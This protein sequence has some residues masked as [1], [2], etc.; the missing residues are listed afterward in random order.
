MLLRGLA[1]PLRAIVTNDE[2]VL[3]I[4][5]QL[6]NE[7]GTPCALPSAIS[8]YRDKS[9]MQAVF[10]QAGLPVPRSVSKEEDRSPEQKV[11]VK[12]RDEA[13]LRGISVTTREALS[14]Y[15][16]KGKVIEEFLEGPQFHCELLVR[17]GSVTPLFAGHYVR[18]LLELAAG[19]IS[20]S[21][22]TRGAHGARVEELAVAACEALGVDGHFVAHAEFLSRGADPKE[23]VLGE[24]CARAPGGEVPFQSRVIAG[25]DLETANLCLQAGIEPRTSRH[26]GSES[27]GWLWSSRPIDVDPAFVDP[28][29]PGVRA[30]SGRVLAGYSLRLS[31]ESLD[32]V[33]G[34][35]EKIVASH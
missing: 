15:D 7:M 34:L 25:I 26:P 14:E 4:A 2:Y 20:G 35:A 10:A 22:E 31:G 33:A 6:S 12:P 24:I 5:Q 16:L 1:D 8:R 30:E 32:A 27:A 23:I 18:P 29:S 19:K 11:I 3:A 13:N 21:V 28:G 9:V 17:E